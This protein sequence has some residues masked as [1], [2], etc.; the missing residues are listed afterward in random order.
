MK[1]EWRAQNGVAP[2]ALRMRPPSVK[3]GRAAR[4]AMCL[5]ESPPSSRAKATLLFQPR[6]SD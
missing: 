3:G 6:L 2:P 1:S 5:F 4:L